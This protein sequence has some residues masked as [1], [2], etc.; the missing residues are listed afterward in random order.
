MNPPIP[1]DLVDHHLDAVLRAAGSG[2]RYYTLP[3]VV[4]SMRKAMRAAMLA[5][6]DR[7]DDHPAAARRVGDFIVVAFSVDY[8]KHLAESHPQLE[9]YNSK[10]DI[11]ETPTVT[12]LNTFADEVV[13]TLNHESENGS[14]IINRALD[15]ALIEC[16][17]QGAE[18]VEVPT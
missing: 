14:T 12:D 15:E 4:Q 9:R 3:G 2:L 13:R 10:T 5:A 18:G 16:I 17:E 6:L 8:V 1:P 7:R 11:Y